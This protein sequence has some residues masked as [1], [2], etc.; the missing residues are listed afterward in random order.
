MPPPTPPI[1][2]SMRK[3]Q[4]IN[5]CERLAVIS[6]KEA[7]NLTPRAEQLNTI[8]HMNTMTNTSIGIPPAP[9]LLIKPT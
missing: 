1:D 4:F 2:P 5:L 3:H 7:F 8:T 6:M 9:I